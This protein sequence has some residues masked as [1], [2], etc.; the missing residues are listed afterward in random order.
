MAKSKRDQSELPPI[1]MVRKGMSLVPA[2]AFSEE[3]LDAIRTNAPIDV[4]WTYELTNPKRKK[5]WAVLNNV[6]KNCRT[7]W[8]NSKAAADSLKHHLGVIDQFAT[9]R[10]DPVKYPGSTLDLTDEEFDVFYEGAM[11][12]LHR[13]TG[14]D[15]EGLRRSSA[16]VQGERED[17]WQAQER[18]DHEQ[19]ATDNV[20]TAPMTVEQE[21]PEPGSHE[22]DER[23]M[24]NAAEP[25]PSKMKDST[26]TKAPVFD[27]GI[28]VDLLIA[29]ATMTPGTVDERRAAVR[30]AGE[31]EMAKWP[32]QHGFIGTAIH[33]CDRVAK[34]DLR[35]G[36]A[37]PYLKSIA[38]KT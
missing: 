10:G 38:P 2:D 25:A 5:F 36:S 21:E 32:A 26:L 9:M 28:I 7:P 31:E 29:K 1:R 15:P 27:P 33:H 17:G 35:A 34:G 22:P 16:K 8:T 24:V 4:S 18:R 3:M 30:K 20:D 13:I 6:I 19:A 11:A 37:S 14:I 23:E 12:T